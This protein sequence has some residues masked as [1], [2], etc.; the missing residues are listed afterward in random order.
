MTL[1]EQIK[2]KAIELGFDLVGVTDASPIDA[3]QAEEFIRWLK[4]GY[5]GQMDFMHSGLEK[6]IAPCK[7]LAGAESVIVVGLN[8]NPPHLSKAKEAAAGQAG[9]L[10]LVAAYAQYEDYHPFIKGQLRKLAQYLVSVAGGGI[11]FKICVDSSPLAERAI[12]AR[13]GLGFIA[14]NHMLTNPRVGARILLGEI[15]TTLKLEPDKPIAH[16]CGECSSCI[17]ACPTKALS[18]DGFFDATKCISYLTIEHKGQIAPHLASQV[19]NRIFGCGEC[20][21]ACPYQKTA[22]CRKNGNFRFHP[23]R[24]AIE[25][26]RVLAMTAEQFETEF[27]GSP[28]MR[29]GLER[30]KRNAQICVANCCA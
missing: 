6:R 9:C 30:L 15:V 25:C 8:Y 5:A 28:I 29:T 16:D 13:A 20:I 10:G 17:A 18:P 3:R 24:A 1:T 2:Q 7:L 12:A 26:D 23:E 22:P 4:C 21:A 27:A 19:S 14:R 11:K